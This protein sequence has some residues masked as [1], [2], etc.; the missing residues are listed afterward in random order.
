M[1]RRS[2]IFFLLTVSTGFALAL[3]FPISPSPGGALFV[4]LGDLRASLMDISAIDRSFRTAFAGTFQPQ[5]FSAGLSLNGFESGSFRVGALEPLLSEFPDALARDLLSPLTMTTF[6][7]TTLRDGLPQSMLD[8]ARSHPV[9]S[10]VTLHYGASVGYRPVMES[11]GLTDPAM[12]KTLMETSLLYPQTLS[13]QGSLGLDV[14]LSK[15]VTF[16]FAGMGRFAGLSSSRGAYLSMTAPNGSALSFSGMDLSLAY[17]D[18]M[19]SGR[20]AGASYPSMLGDKSRRS[21]FCLSDY[22][23]AGGIRFT[24]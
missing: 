6:D 17:Y 16:V 1:I 4:S 10:T 13:G 15:H 5:Q 3:D 23:V 24:F 21:T 2:F 14:T 11:A 18:A 8:M 19:L 22:S 12:V 7:A 9:T 20:E